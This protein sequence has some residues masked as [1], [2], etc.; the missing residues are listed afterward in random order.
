MAIVRVL[1]RLQSLESPEAFSEVEF[2]ADMP[3]PDTSPS[4]YGDGCPGGGAQ[5][6]AEHQARSQLDPKRVWLL[7]VSAEQPQSAPLLGE[8][9]H[10]AHT[11]DS[12]HELRAG[13]VAGLQQ[14]AERLVADS[15]DP[16]GLPEVSK[17]DVKSYARARFE[18]GDPE[19]V[20]FE[21]VCLRSSWRRTLK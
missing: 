8:E 13:S 20:R 1:R 3:E 12:H 16:E 5:I 21:S 2:R 4:C 19:W 9:I 15:P 14:L 11:C 6:V 18:A 10:F 7:D 17:N